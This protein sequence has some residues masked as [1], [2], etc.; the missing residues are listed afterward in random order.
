MSSS[1]RPTAPNANPSDSEPDLDCEEQREWLD[2]NLDCLTTQCPRCGWLAQYPDCEN[3]G[4]LFD[5]PGEE[6]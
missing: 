3:C 6:Q 4:F 5:W 2:R 1:H